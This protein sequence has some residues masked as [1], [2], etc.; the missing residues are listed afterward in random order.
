MVKLQAGNKCQLERMRRQFVTK[1][2]KE[3]AVRSTQTHT[4]SMMR[5]R[6]KT[7]KW[8]FREPKTKVNRVVPI[9]RKLKSFLD[10]YNP[11]V[12][13]G[14][15]FFIIPTGIRFDPDNLSRYLR[16]LMMKLGLTGAVLISGIRLEVS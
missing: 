11:S 12:V 15:W 6:A 16:N 14:K 1:A 7:V 2:F 4:I 10:S 13:E 8:E 3:G 9:S 5:I